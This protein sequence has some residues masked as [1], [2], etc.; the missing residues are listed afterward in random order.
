MA[1]YATKLQLHYMLFRAIR[2]LIAL[3]TSKY[4]KGASREMLRDL[5]GELNTLPPGSRKHF[6]VGRHVERRSL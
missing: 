5:L 1:R 2:L 6:M 4:G 3:N